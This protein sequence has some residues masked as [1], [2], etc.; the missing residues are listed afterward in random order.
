MKESEYVSSFERVFSE[1]CISKYNNKY[2]VKRKANLLYEININPSMKL[3]I[4]DIEH[5]KRGISA[6]QTDLC[7]F[8]RTKTLEVPRVV[9]EFKTRVTTHDIFVYSAKAGKHKTIYPY[10][11]YGLIATSIE[12]IPGRFFT[13]N[14]HLDFAFA[15]KT[16]CDRK[17]DLT[18]KLKAILKNEIAESVK[19]ENMFYSGS[20]HKYYSKSIEYNDK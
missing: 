12:K 5:P 1:I 19:L 6:F 3:D 4:E 14:E 11:R 20:E 10:L 18:I 17:D 16:I 13:H 2:V 8:E 15:A 7:I 9:F